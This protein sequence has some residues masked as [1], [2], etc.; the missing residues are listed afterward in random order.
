MQT[1]CGETTTLSPFVVLVSDVVR[2][3]FYAPAGSR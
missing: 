1:I 3:G 2:R